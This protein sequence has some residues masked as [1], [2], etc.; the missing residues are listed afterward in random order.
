MLGG[1]GARPVRHARGAVSLAGV[2]H[3]FFVGSLALRCRGWMSIGVASV[4]WLA[5]GW[6]G[7]IKQ[8]VQVS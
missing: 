8:M 3:G 6:S 7:R 5:G 4:A 2:R 1:T